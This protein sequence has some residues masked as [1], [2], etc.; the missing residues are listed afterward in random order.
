MEPHLYLYEQL[1]LLSMKDDTGLVYSYDAINQG[2]YTSGGAVLMDLLM[3]GGIAISDKNHCFSLPNRPSLN[4]EVLEKA[5]SRIEK[6]KKTKDAKYWVQIFATYDTP[7]RKAIKHLIAKDVV[8][9]DKQKTWGFFSKTRY[10]LQNVALKQGIIT[11]LE[12]A[13]DPISPSDRETLILLGLVKSAKLLPHVFP[14]HFRENPTELIAKVE[15][16]LKKK[17]QDNFVEGALEDD[18]KRQEMFEAIEMSLNTLAFALDSVLDAVDSS[19]GDAGGDG[20][21]GGGDGG[22]GD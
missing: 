3:Q 22:G 10:P 2:I 19:I 15:T 13:L 5:L 12:A 1:Q 18:Q 9:L 14:R 4:D 6:A 17:P 8:R 11:N 7:Y 20:G 21:D 16:A